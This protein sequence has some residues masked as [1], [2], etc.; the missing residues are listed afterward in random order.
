[1][2][3]SLAERARSADMLRR[4]RTTTCYKCM[5]D[6]FYNRY[7]TR[8]DPHRFSLE[9]HSIFNEEKISLLVFLY[10]FK[11]G[12][13]SI[14]VRSFCNKLRTE[15]VRI[16]RCSTPLTSN[17]RTVVVNTAT[18][19]ISHVYNFSQASASKRTQESHT[20]RLLL[21]YLLCVQHTVPG[22]KKLGTPR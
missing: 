21:L 4:N 8:I 17:N 10:I 3:R 6:H 5:C 14:V 13:K 16:T 22:I 7:L 1:M 15:L 11:R 18:F 20:Y 9:I 12:R 19:S 2:K